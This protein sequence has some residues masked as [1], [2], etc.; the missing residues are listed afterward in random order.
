M[1]VEAA[2]SGQLGL[3]TRA[4]CVVLG[5]VYIYIFPEDTTFKWDSCTAH[6][7]LRTMGGEMV[8]LKESL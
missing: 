4:F 1:Y 6:A 2:Y 5:L 3:V 7:I 8:E